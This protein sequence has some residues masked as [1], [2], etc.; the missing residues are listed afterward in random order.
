MPRLRRID[1][2]LPAISRRRRGGGSSTREQYRY[3]DLWR[4]RRD[5]EKFD[6]M[7]DFPRLLLLNLG[8]FRIRLGGLRR[9]TRPD[10]EMECTGTRV[11]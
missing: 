4:E 5:R 8:F 2:A 3:H 1:C 10:R 9:P 6:A 7:V 11:M